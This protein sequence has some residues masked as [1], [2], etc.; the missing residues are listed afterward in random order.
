[1]PSH[2]MIFSFAK[3]LQCKDVRMLT[4]LCSVF[5]KSYIHMHPKKIKETTKALILFTYQ[6]TI[7]FFF[8]CCQFVQHI[9]FSLNFLI[10]LKK[11]KKSRT[12]KNVLFV[13]HVK[14]VHKTCF[15]FFLRSKHTSI[16]VL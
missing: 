3:I 5:P 4:Y 16:V 2:R 13:I 14:R 12:H 6:I 1:M 11:F 8:H 9:N 7:Q 10:Y 15:T